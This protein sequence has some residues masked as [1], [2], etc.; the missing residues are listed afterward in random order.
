[1]SDQYNN[2]EQNYGSSQ[3]PYSSQ[4]SSQYESSQAGA[5]NS[6]FYTADEKSYFDSSQSSQ[7]ETIHS[8]DTWSQSPSTFNSSGTEWNGSQYTT[9]TEDKTL[10]WSS[11]SSSSSWDS[12]NSSQKHELFDASKYEF[13]SPDDKSGSYESSQ[14]SQN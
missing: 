2:N 4:A 8:Q 11:N 1:M 12:P 6:S 3:D 5:Y 13:G 7:G 10:A 14:G 9:C